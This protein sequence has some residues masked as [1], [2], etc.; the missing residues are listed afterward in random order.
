MKQRDAGQVNLGQPQPQEIEVTRLQPASE[1]HVVTRWQ[2]VLQPSQIT[3][4]ISIAE[5]GDVVRLQP[6]Q[7]VPERLNGRE[8]DHGRQYRS[9]R[10]PS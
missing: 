3:G 6:S 9:P 1:F 7:Q 2:S 5:P 10:T 4:A 8:V